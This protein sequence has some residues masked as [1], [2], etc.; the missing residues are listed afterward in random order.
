[1]S[2][3]ST[4]AQ[5]S[6]AQALRGSSPVAGLDRRSLGPLP[7]LAQSVS[8][9]APAAAMATTP[10]LVTVQAGTSAL[11]SVALAALLALLVSACVRTFSIRMAAPGALYSFTAK[12]LGPAAAFACGC[13]LLIGYGVL[14]MGALTGTGLYAGL[15]CARLGLTAWPPGL[16]GLP[17]V[18]TLSAAGAL[19]AYFLVR[20]VRLS[21]GLALCLEVASIVLALAFFAVLLVR[22]GPHPDMRQLAPPEANPGALASVAAG[23]LPAFGA[24]IG[25]ESATVLGAEA[26]RPFL[27]VG[28][29][30]RWTVVCSAALYLLATYTQVL[31]T[32]GDGVLSPLD[33]PG[34]HPAVRLPVLLDL[35]IAISF[36]ACAVA[37]GTALVRLL[38]SMGRERMTPRRLGSTHPTHGTPHIAVRLVLPF[39]VLVPLGL[40]AAG[41]ELRTVFSLLLSLC[42]YGFL[43]AYALVCLAAPV[44]LHRI[45]ELT[46]GAVA[47][48][49]VCV[50]SL[51]LVLAAH[52]R[53]NLSAGNALVPGL[54]T[55]LMGAGTVWF[56][57]ARRR[58]PERIGRIGVY[59][60]TSAADVLHSASA[61]LLH[62]PV[63]IAHQ[64]SGPP[65]RRAR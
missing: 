8:A 39:L 40:L 30:V 29:A 13:A 24:F 28:R 19:T 36:F 63:D 59:D 10:A 12:G 32:G 26:R 50:P 55:L 57:I 49:A 34:R 2:A 56:V 6:S 46:R 42:T 51:L 38:F 60:E 23:A 3:T 62:L 22:Q 45:G 44:F 16:P 65:A 35:G 52:A 27:V 54:F 20:G 14:V 53:L 21:A 48:A 41:L 31:P 7:V 11:W 9:V 43:T 4:S 58:D 47:T 61:T 33:D 18:L 64:Q 1:M 17:V 25:F 37:S 15:L 5:A